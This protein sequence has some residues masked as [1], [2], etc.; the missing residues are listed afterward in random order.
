ML[1]NLASKMLYYA[2][3]TLNIKIPTS[4]VE[5]FLQVHTCTHTRIITTHIFRYTYLHKCLSA[6][7]CLLVESK[8][9]HKDNILEKKHDAAK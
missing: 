3:T 9:V 4:T 2:R 7:K 6:N 8:I 1:L 5:I